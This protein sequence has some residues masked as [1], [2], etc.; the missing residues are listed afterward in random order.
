LGL[1]EEFFPYFPTPDVLL[2]D[3]YSSN[4]NGGFIINPNVA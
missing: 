1:I 2:L 3:S 4:L